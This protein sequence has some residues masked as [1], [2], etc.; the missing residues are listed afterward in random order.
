MAGGNSRKRP[1]G[2]LKSR[3]SGKDGSPGAAG[4]CGGWAWAIFTLVSVT[5]VLLCAAQFSLGAFGASGGLAHPSL[6]KGRLLRG[7]ADGSDDSAGA[8]WLTEALVVEPAPG[9]A[10]R[11]RT[12]DVRAEKPGSGEVAATRQ[13]PS[14]PTAKPQQTQGAV[15]AQEEERQQEEGQGELPRLGP[16]RDLALGR[17]ARSDVRGNLGAAS[18][19]TK[20]GPGKNWLKDR[21]QAAADMNGTP[22]K[23]EHWLAIEMEEEGAHLT[24]VVIDFEDAHA[25]E[26]IL[27]TGDSL[28]GPWHE[29]ATIEE[30]STGGRPVGFAQI[31][32]GG[33]PVKVQ[34]RKQHV[35]HTLEKP[36][37]SRWLARK[38]VRVRFTKPATAWGVSV[39]RLRMFG[40]MPLAAGL[41][42]DV[43]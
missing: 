19:I 20:A 18:L 43:A 30:Q 10:V 12:A 2:K 26:Y 7:G 39:W 36:E 23:G 16:E 38:Y 13:L 40:Q 37:E 9:D 22:L 29:L 21:W 8:D 14:E 3:G 41:E 6:P 27:E 28:R 32:P 34:S 4:G 31:W 24:R 35:E 42:V 25:A 17:P 15:A 11:P 5:L 1:A 33:G